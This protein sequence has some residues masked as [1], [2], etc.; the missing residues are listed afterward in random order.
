MA[1]LSEAETPAIT[2]EEVATDGSDLSN[3]AADH[4]RLFL[5][6]DGALHLRDSAGTITDVADAG[7]GPL[8]NFAASA[9]LDG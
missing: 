4:R 9:A 6:E 7:S 2:L 3:P 8:N 1:K 5:G